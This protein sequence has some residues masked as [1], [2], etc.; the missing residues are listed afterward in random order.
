MDACHTEDSAA[1]KLQSFRRSHV[2]RRHAEALKD[3]RD[4][5][6]IAGCF[7]R[8][9]RNNSGDLDRAEL[10]TA[11]MELTGLTL[12]AAQVAALMEE[13]GSS[14]DTLTLDQFT[15]LLRTFDFGVVRESDDAAAAYPQRAP[16]N[17]AEASAAVKLQSL[18][19]SHVA[20]RHAEALKDSRDL[21]I[22]AGCF[23]RFDRNNSGALDRAELGTAVMELTGLTLSAAQVAALM[24]ESGSSGDTLTLDQFTVLL[25]TFDFGVGSAG[26]HDAAAAAAAPPPPRKERFDDRALSD[27]ATGAEL[28][29]QAEHEAARVVYERVLRDMEKTKGPWHPYTARAL[30]GLATALAGLER[31]EEARPQGERAVAVYAA[32]AAKLSEG[33][34]SESETHQALAD[35]ADARNNL[36]VIMYKMR[37]SNGEARR[38]FEEALAG[39][40]QLFG[41]AHAMV[42]RTLKNLG[43]TMKRDGD[44]ASALDAYGE[45]L[46]IYGMALGPYSSARAMTLNNLANV[47][48]KELR[49]DDAVDHYRR[50]LH[51]YA[52]VSERIGAE[53]RRGQAV[54]EEEAEVWGL[55]GRAAVVRRRVDADA[56]RTRHN[57]ANVL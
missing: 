53:A 15:V 21:D 18:R 37:S 44:N 5:D 34:A 25:R 39:Y 46:K 38:L 16:R 11:V 6:I 2:A 27:M 55:G 10:G 4:L 28:N 33:P 9:D 17:Q 14:G 48:K 41:P 51:C 42:A 54:S 1:V 8:F 24:E 45:A 26:S 40:R 35:L 31:Y 57:L 20:R 49:F 29:E 23:A 47:L 19:R 56:S 22:I 3:S 30:N 13:S 43:N 52:Q 50:A 7:A 12:S 36:G 32:A